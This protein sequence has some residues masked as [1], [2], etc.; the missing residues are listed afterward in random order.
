[1]MIIITIM[2]AIIAATI[3]IMIHVS[4]L[5]DSGIERAELT[6]ILRYLILE[7]KQVVLVVVV[8]V[9]LSGGGGGGGSSSSSSSSTSSS[10]KSSS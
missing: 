1:M 5:E 3:T 4:S 2:R 7:L 9:A 10:S 8:V 6:I